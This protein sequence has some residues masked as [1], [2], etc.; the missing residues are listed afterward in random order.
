MAMHRL[1]KDK[2]QVDLM[3]LIAYLYV[4]STPIGKVGAV[5]I[6]GGVG[7][8][9]TYRIEGLVRDQDGDTFELSKEQ[10]VTVQHHYDDG[11]CSLMSEV[12]STFDVVRDKEY[13]LKK[14]KELTDLERE[15][16]INDY[17]DVVTADEKK[18]KGHAAEPG[19]LL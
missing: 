3:A 10:G 1:S 8:M 7:E 17:G 13:R 19:E 4:N 11:A 18:L 14:L 12:L 2:E 5:R 6:N 15:M 16:G 9:C